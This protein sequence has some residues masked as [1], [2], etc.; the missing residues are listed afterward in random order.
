MKFPSNHKTFLIYLFVCMNIYS[1][2]SF[3][4]SVTKLIENK[5]FRKVEILLKKEISIKNNVRLIELLGDV[6]GYQK[7]WEEAKETYKKLVNINSNNANYL[8][9]YGG[10]LGMIALENKFKGLGLID[11]VKKYFAKAAEL[12]P[13]H[14]NVRWA[15][16]ELYIQLPG[17]VGGSYKKAEEYALQLSEISPLEGY[18]AKGYIADYRKRNYEAEMNFK[19]AMEHIDN[20]KENYPRNNLNYQIGKIAATYNINLNKGLVHLNRFIKNH[21]TSDNVTLDWIYYQMARIFKLK[22]DKSNALISIE[23]ALALKPGFTLAQKEKKL[24]EAM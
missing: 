7:K 20:V 24:I 11:D 12:D 21:S 9:K 23:K 2:N 16:I 17:I 1:Q 13:Q 5:E 22:G 6:Y 10:V 14:I 15:L 18:L 8:Y 19:K 4:Q 3:E